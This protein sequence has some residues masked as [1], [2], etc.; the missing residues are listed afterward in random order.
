MSDVVVYFGPQGENGGIIDAVEH[1]ILDLL[2]A[3][4]WALRYGTDA[5]ISVLRVD[6]IMY[7]SPSLRLDSRAKLMSFSLVFAACHERQEDPYPSKVATLIGMT[8]S[9]F[10]SDFGELFSKLLQA[11]P[12][13]AAVFSSR[14]PSISFAPHLET[15]PFLDTSSLSISFSRLCK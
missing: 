14:I 12:S 1:D 10:V 11:S 6:S 2:A 15:K 5:A 3:T 7:V 4:R 9:L 8:I 13:F